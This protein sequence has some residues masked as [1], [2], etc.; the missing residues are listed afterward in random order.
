MPGIA[1]IGEGISTLSGAGGPTFTHV[2]M[3]GPL[4]LMTG[5]YE[6]CWN[7]ASALINPAF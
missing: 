1:P 7:I 3:P 4:K 2:E 6:E 5:R